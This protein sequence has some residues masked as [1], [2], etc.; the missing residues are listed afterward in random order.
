[1]AKTR[2]RPKGQRAPDRCLPARGGR[3]APL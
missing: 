1:M 3:L 2:R